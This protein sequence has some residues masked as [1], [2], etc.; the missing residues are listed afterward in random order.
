MICLH[1]G[2]H[3]IQFQKSLDGG[4][5]A[6]KISSVMFVGMTDS[7]SVDAKHA[8]FQEPVYETTQIS[9]H[10]VEHEIYF[11]AKGD[12]ML[13]KIQPDSYDDL[14]RFS[15]RDS[16]MN[17][18][19]TIGK[20]DQHVTGNQIKSSVLSNKARKGRY[21][22]PLQET[23]SYATKRQSPV[24]SYKVQRGKYHQETELSTIAT[25]PVPSNKAQKEKYHQ[26]TESSIIT[27]K[28]PP[29]V[30]RLSRFTSFLRSYRSEK[31]SKSFVSVPVSLQS[32]YSSTESVAVSLQSRHSS[33]ESLSSDLFSEPVFISDLF[34]KPAPS[35]NIFSTPAFKPSYLSSTPAFKPSYLSSTPAF[36]PSYLSSRP[37][38]YHSSRS[39]SNISSNPAFIP[40]SS[41]QSQ[42]SPIESVDSL[43]SDLF[44][45]PVF[46]SDLF[47]KPALASSKSAFSAL[48]P[49]PKMDELPQNNDQPTLEARRARRLSGDESSKSLTEAAGFEDFRK[50]LTLRKGGMV[51]F[52]H[53]L[54]AGS[55]HH[56]NE[57][58]P[59]FVK[60][61]SLCVL[62]TGS[63]EAIHQE[64]LDMLQA[65]SYALKAMVVQVCANDEPVPKNTVS[66]NASLSH[67][68]KFL[69]RKSDD[70]FDYM[71]SLNLRES[72]ESNIRASILAHTLSSSSSKMFPFSWYLFGFRL[73][74]FMTS[75]NKS[76]ASVSSECMA[77]AKGLAMDRP[78]VEAALEHLMEHNIILYF[79]DVLND[80]VFLNVQIF[81]QILSSLFEKSAHSVNG[82][83]SRLTFYEA[84]GEIGYHVDKYDVFL[85]FT[86]LLIMAPYGFKYFIP[87]WLTL[88]NEKDREEACSAASDSDLSPLYFICP[89]SG[90]EFI[91][92]LAV[93]L[94]T[95]PTS[96]WKIFQSGR[97]TPVCLFKNCMKFNFDDLCVVTIS[98]FQGCVQVYVK[99]LKEAKRNVFD[100]SATVLRGLERVKLLLNSHQFFTFNMSFPCPC[101]RDEHVHTVTY[102]NDD[103]TLKCIHG[104]VTAT[105]SITQWLIKPGMP[106]VEKLGH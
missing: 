19:T 23:A 26:E 103:H 63:S 89:S 101:G 88:L 66:K 75:E 47:S 64:E 12:P 9:S 59:I 54:K 83:F 44:S 72:N 17:G 37:V 18:G 24:P 28:H 104:D 13:R 25:S 102:H 85:L 58:L 8:I 32:Q 27:T 38:L 11:R 5:L 40:S 60:N 90:N 76:T 39:S 56:M 43:S 35:S 57:I 81:S 62:V 67:H 53:V 105:S 80:T 97:K 55:H 21:Y 51:E 16:S 20:E 92:M 36:K 100:I 42:Y 74:L 2:D 45:E 49:E 50:L 3:S 33:I 73:R 69:I 78:T 87:C 65:N 68:S 31:R 94:L 77:I 29:K 14:I 82:S 15:M 48:P 95:K 99:S 4:S 98:F 52:F 1:S 41:L 91:A 93:F 71:F 106:I 70:P 84:I 30:N 86:K 7:L 34:S 79:R 96:E 10:L 22:Q 46:I 61:I 6:I